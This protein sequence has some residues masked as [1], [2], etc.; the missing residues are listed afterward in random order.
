MQLVF[1]GNICCILKSAK[2]NI[3]N[4]TSW[5]EVNDLSTARMEMVELEQ[6]QLLAARWYT[7]FN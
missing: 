6:Q 1:G 5:T 2:Q 3:W 7:P 4:G